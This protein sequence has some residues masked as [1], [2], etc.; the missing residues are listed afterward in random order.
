MSEPRPT[1]GLNGPRVTP[2]PP[3][4]RA[5]VLL[6]DDDAELREM[7]REMLESSGYDV[8][9]ASNGREALDLLHQADPPPGLILLDLMMPIMTGEEMLAALKQVHALA[10]IPVTIVS[11]HDGPPEGT[12]YLKKPVDF[13][14]LLG[15][16]QKTCG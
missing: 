10:A 7:L 4:P 12:A 2:I 9:C 8:Y 14:A 11:G 15:V 3:N 13:S 6:V 5:P 16:V 1:D